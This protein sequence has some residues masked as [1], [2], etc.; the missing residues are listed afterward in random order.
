MDVQ[1]AQVRG[2]ARQFHLTELREYTEY[3]F[4]ASA[5]SANGEGALSE[6]VTARTHSAAPADPPENCT[7][8]AA[9]ATAIVV[10]WE[11]PPEES[12]NGVITGYK[13]R[14]RNGGGK[15]TEVVTTDGSRRLYAISGLKNGREYQIKVAAMTVN[16]T[17]P[18]T[19]WMSERTLSADLDESVVPDPPTSLTARA[20]SNS[21]K[22]AWTPP[23]K[24]AG[25]LVRGYTI[26]WGV[27][28]PDEYTKVVDDK[29]RGFVIEGLR[30]N[31]EYV[32]S[33]RAYNGVGDGRPVYES[34]RTR[35]RSADGADSAPLA[36][37]IGIHARILSSKTALLTWID[38]TLPRNQV[39]LTI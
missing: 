14:W 25:I 23:D 20:K 4:W 6:E 30:P 13:I 26:G 21:V 12:R 2:D 8:E 29:E 22:L 38:S 9:G 10:R 31:S 39:C 5:F 17:G 33:L 18:S 28:I 37:P 35:V 11:P 1:S 16:G 24:S 15:K 34:V 7:A 32:I 27:G 3:A 36:P 19:P